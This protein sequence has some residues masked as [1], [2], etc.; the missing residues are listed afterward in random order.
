M[1]LLS[2]RPLTQLARVAKRQG[3]QIEKNKYKLGNYSVTLAYGE[4]IRYEFDNDAVHVKYQDL[5]HSGYLLEIQC[6]NTSMKAVYNSFRDIGYVEFDQDYAVDHGD[7]A[8]YQVISINGI[9]PSIDDMGDLPNR[10]LAHDIGNIIKSIDPLSYPLNIDTRVCDLPD[11]SLESMMS[12]HK[13]AILDMYSDGYF[14]PISPDSLDPIRFK[15]QDGD[16]SYIYDR[17]DYS[18]E[19]LVRNK[20]SIFIDIEDWSY[21]ASFPLNEESTQL[22]DSYEGCPRNDWMLLDYITNFPF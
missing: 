2:S 17:D 16:Y 19:I 18:L 1:S 13:K 14:V 22:L 20:G 5:G 7:T 12:I 11:I 21:E 15:L 3:V 8:W 4:V 9:Y 10:E 6:L